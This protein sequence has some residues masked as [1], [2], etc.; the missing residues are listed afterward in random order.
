MKTEK[1]TFAFKLADKRQS[2]ARW[3]ARDGVALAACSELPNGNYRDNILY[4]P[5]GPPVG[6]DKGYFC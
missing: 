2:G 4:W 5:G 1:K 6:E 3:T